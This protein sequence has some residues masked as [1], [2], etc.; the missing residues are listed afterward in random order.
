MWL[1]FVGAQSIIVKAKNAHRNAKVVTVGNCSYVRCLHATF[2]TRG[3]GEKEGG[4]GGGA[5]GKNWGN[6]DYLNNDSKGAL[7]G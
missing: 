5:K 7:G 4:E 2:G 6:E 1:R 3:V